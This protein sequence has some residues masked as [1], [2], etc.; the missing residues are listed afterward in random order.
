MLQ[1]VVNQGHGI[2]DYLGM[3]RG[4]VQFR[5][6]RT[7]MFDAIL[8]AHFDGLVE[9]SDQ[10]KYSILNNSWYFETTSWDNIR[11]V[12]REKCSTSSLLN[13]LNE[14]MVAKKGKLI[15]SNLK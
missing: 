4:N 1:N 13:M 9:L 2:L 5:K 8:D 11:Y 6:V 7:M 12:T 10:P 15:K 14:Y 3:K